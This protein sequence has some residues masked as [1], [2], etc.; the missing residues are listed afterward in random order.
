MS[1]WGRFGS[2]VVEG[3]GKGRPLRLLADVIAMYA[4][5]TSLTHPAGGA[6]LTAGRPAPTTATEPRTGRTPVRIP[7]PRA[8]LDD[9]SWPLEHRPEAAGEARHLAQELLE[10]WHVA[11]DTADGVLLVVSELVTNAVEHARAPI[12]LHL[13][14][15]H[16][17]HRIWIGVSDGGPADRDGAWTRSCADDEHGRGLGLV[18]ALAEAHGT[19][20]HTGGATHWA[21]LAAA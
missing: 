11:D 5:D 16:A 6:L 21:R 7:A 14:R 4:T 20:T 19:R 10:H 13:H 8:P 15:E 18:D 9:G 2:V 1:D 3:P 12:V 17:D